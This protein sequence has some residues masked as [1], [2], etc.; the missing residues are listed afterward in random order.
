VELGDGRAGF[1]G[2][3][4]YAEPEPRLKLR[5]PG[6]PWHWGKVAFEKWWLHHWL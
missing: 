1:A 2:G 6:R 5:R 4:F 3:D